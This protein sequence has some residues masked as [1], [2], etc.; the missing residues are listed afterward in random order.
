MYAPITI[1]N[2][3]IY[4]AIDEGSKITPMKALKL[5]YIS[6]GWHLALKKE[7]LI[8]E[9]AEA[10]K[11]G[12]VV[13]SVYQI[14][15]KYGRCDI[16]GVQLVNSMVK[17][18]FSELLSNH[19]DRDFLDKIW[20][21]YKKY[22]GTELSSLTHMVNTPWHITWHKKGGSLKDGSIIPN[23]LIKSYYEKKLQANVSEPLN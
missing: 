6:H 5:V 1:A 9:Q 14:L 2:Y 4:K 23:S 8:T 7:P 13:G 22:S 19:I 20:D 11:Y 21:V 17:S 18:E 16:D 15:K 3:F 12:P 10:W